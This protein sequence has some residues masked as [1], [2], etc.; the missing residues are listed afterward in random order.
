MKFMTPEKQRAVCQL[1]G[2]QAKFAGKKAGKRIS[3]EKTVSWNNATTEFRSKQHLQW[4]E[5]GIR[6]K[7]YQHFSSQYD[8]VSTGT[9]ELVHD[10]GRPESVYTS[11]PNMVFVDIVSQ[12]RRE[13]IS[14]SV[15]VVFDGEHP[16]LSN[17]SATPFVL[18]GRQYGS[19]EAFI[20]S[21]KYPLG[22]KRDSV[23]LLSGLFAQRAGENPNKEICKCLRVGD[24]VFLH[25]SR[26]IKLEFQSPQHLSAIE[27][28]IRA[29]F[30]QNADAMS[31]LNATKQRP[32]IHNLTKAHQLT[33]SLTPK[34]FCA[35]LFRIRKN[36]AHPSD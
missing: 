35:I 36:E 4:I 10:T 8:L 14:T 23:E 17:L 9:S 22:P 1:V 29:K 28:A 34:Q 24:R 12:I 16:V 20:Q 2:K 32:L 13:L 18:D 5:N 7:F 21:L 19:V 6:T 31:S 11:L 33:T 27:T 30:E 3:R 26:E 15:N 25:T